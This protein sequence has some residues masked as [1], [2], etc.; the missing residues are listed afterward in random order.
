V[1]PNKINRKGYFDHD[2]KTQ[3]KAGDDG[4]EE[5]METAAGVTLRGRR[6]WGLGQC[7]D[8]S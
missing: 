4:T 3:Q 8:W 5:G 2:G 1:F 7:R 6:G